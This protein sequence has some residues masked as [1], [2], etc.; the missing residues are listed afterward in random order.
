MVPRMGAILLDG[1]AIGVAMRGEHLRATPILFLHGVGSDKSVWA[2]QLAHF[3]ERRP[4]IAFDYPGYGESALRPGASRDDF[5]GAM[6]DTLDALGIDQAHIC[7][8]SLGGIVAL[9]M[10][11]CSPVRCASLILAD[12]FAAH[13]E[14]EAFHARSVEASRT[15]SMRDLATARAPML[16]G[17]AASSAIRDEV[18]ET[19]SA[20]DP[21][22]YRLGAAAVWLADQRERAAAVD[23][24]TLILVGDE[25][26]ITPPALSAELNDLIDGAQ[27]ECIT[28]AGH[29]S[30]IEQPDRFNSAIEQF[31]SNAE[32]R[33][34]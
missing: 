17:N 28:G 15:M 8:L 24:P 14:G 34:A 2:P 20:I 19:M 11:H 5:A 21:E 18:I 31:L 32:R 22:A 7:G 13:P 29:L 10:H 12:S 4:A 30:N 25:D 6:F 1:G 23:V 27:Y 26:R 9:A 3:A 16:L 33:I